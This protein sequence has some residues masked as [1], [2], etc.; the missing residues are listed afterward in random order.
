MTLK[1]AATVFVVGFLLH[2]AD[3]ARRG[4]DAITD[5]VVWAGTAVAMIA[6]VVLTLVC[7]DHQSAP[8]A[9][10]AAGFGI[11]VGVSATHLL[12]DWGVLSDPLLDL[13]ATSWVAVFAEIGGALLL[14][15]T[16]ARRYLA[17]AAPA[18]AATPPP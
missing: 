11:A 16:G 3:H 18:E 4:I 1:A 12:P 14:G 10:A 15:A 13:S 17:A 5:H 7:T 9:S 2:N 8:L 6:A